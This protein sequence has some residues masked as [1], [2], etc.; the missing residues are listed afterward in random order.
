[1]TVSLVSSGIDVKTM[2]NPF[3]EYAIGLS[4]WNQPRKDRYPYVLPVRP[5][6]VP[7]RIGQQGSCF[8]LHMHGVPPATN[9][10]LITIVVDAAGKKTIRGELR[11]LNINEFTIFGDLDHL[12]NEIKR[13]W[14][15]SL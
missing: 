4:F 14:G 7:G 1:M 11:K 3:V 9:G 6:I 12:S 15:V 8:T 10:T 13:T 5:D 2:R